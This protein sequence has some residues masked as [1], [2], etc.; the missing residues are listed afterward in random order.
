MEIKPGDHKPL[1]LFTKIIYGSGDLGIASWGTLRQIFYAIFLTDV[2]GLEARL[3]SFAA[4]IG[5]I[6]DAI[7]DPL[8]GMIS[9]RVSTRWGRRRPFLI[10]FAI[11]FGLAYLLMW[12][13]P[14]WDNQYVLAIHMTLAYII[15]DTLQTLVSVPFYTLTPE[16]TPDYD[17]RTELTT[18]RMFFNLVASLGVAVAAPMI[19][20]AAL[21]SGLTLS[22]SYLLISGLF[23]G[24]GTIPFLLIFFFVRERHPQPSTESP[25]MKSIAETAWKN[26]P[27]RFAT[28]L[29]MLNW[30]TV[31]MVSLILPYFLTYWIAQGNL[32]AEM[33][34]FGSQVSQDS[35]ILGL[36]FITAI[37]ALPGWNWISKKTSKR[38]AYIYGMAFWMVVQLLLITVQPGQTILI[39]VLTVLAGI[40]IATAHVLPEAIFPDVI[41]WEELRTRR[42]HEGVY[43]GAKNFSRKLAGAFTIFLVLQ[44]LGWFGYVSPPEGVTVFQQSETTLLVIRILTGP[45]GAVLLLCSIVIAWFYPLT[46]EKHARI[47][48]LLARRENR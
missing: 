1:P 33:T 42:R 39:L 40:S 43:Y 34:V 4:L 27:F 23:G 8:V 25:S 16:M 18:Y 29:Y 3:A 17:E 45:F 22:Q 47:R 35:V 2:V 6:W 21:Q 24:I 10:I 36:M 14:P 9:D 31:D 28:G 13:A 20:N 48:E 7:N 12:W 41:E 11:P 5:V 44:A 38:M 26:V 30:M 15:S 19:K 32:A 37:V 46:R